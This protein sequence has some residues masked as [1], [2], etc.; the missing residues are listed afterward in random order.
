MQHSNSEKK[1]VWLCPY[2]KSIFAVNV[3]LWGK[4]SYLKTGQQYASQN[5]LFFL[6]W[7]V[8][9]HLIRISSV[10]MKQNKFSQNLF[11]Q[12]QKTFIYKFV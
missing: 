11:W 2:L 10:L 3:V 4:Q 7:E 8:I 6:I 1:K 12:N 9:E 5:T